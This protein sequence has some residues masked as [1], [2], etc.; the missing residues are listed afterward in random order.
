MRSLQIE[1][2]KKYLIGFI[3]CLSACSQ[4]NSNTIHAMRTVQQT[5]PQVPLKAD[6]PQQQGI[7][8]Q[9]KNLPPAYLKWLSE[10]TNAES[11]QAY[12]RFLKQ[13]GISAYVPNFE[14]LQTA[15]DWQ[16]CDASEFEVPPQELWGNIVPTLKILNRLVDEKILTQFSVTSVYRN[17]KLNQCAKGAPSSKHIF[18]AALDF[19]I[20]DENPDLNQQLM[21][22][23]RKAKLCQFWLDSGEEL[24]MG[25][26]VYAS[27]QIHIDSAGFR[28]WGADHRYSS[29]PCINNA[30][31][32]NN[33]KVSES[34]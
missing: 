19:R 8:K 4:N 22:Q 2:N 27:G 29:S 16:Q 15:R 13:Q 6:F 12:Q 10:P 32:G 5:S 7:L 21:I 17:F 18:N 24:H 1:M 33:K 14:F 31:I 3:L 26:G 23:E 20:G 28:T 11:V 9:E 25:L 34:P 30:L